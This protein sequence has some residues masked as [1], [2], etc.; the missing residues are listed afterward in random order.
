MSQIK[1]VCDHRAAKLETISTQHEYLQQSVFK[2]ETIWKVLGEQNNRIT[3]PRL[4]HLGTDEGQNG[5][6]WVTGFSR[7]I[8][9]SFHGFQLVI[10]FSVFSIYNQSSV[11]VSRRGT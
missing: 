9:I 11:S 7:L 6:I 4:S 10:D 2:L 3:M 8:F 1:T 5:L